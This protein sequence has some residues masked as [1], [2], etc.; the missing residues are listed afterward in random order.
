M[1]GRDSGIGK[2]NIREGGLAGFALRPEPRKRV[3]RKVRKSC[4]PPSGGRSESAET[5]STPALS[6][7][8]IYPRKVARWRRVFYSTSPRLFALAAN[9]RSTWSISVESSLKFSKKSGRPPGRLRGY[10]LKFRPNLSESASSQIPPN[11]PAPPLQI[12]P[13]RPMPESFSLQFRPERSR[14]GEF[15][16]PNPAARLRAG[17]DFRAANPFKISSGKDSILRTWRPHVGRGRISDQQA[18]PQ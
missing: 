4:Q 18:F 2:D 11:L 10:R 15:F 13:K 14:L 17:A 1:D 6:S 5:A 3:G 16:A 9:S 12:Q 8:Q 7:S